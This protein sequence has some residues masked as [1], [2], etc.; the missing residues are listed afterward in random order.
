MMKTLTKVL[1]SFVIT[2]SLL[3]L[4]AVCTNNSNIVSTFMRQSPPS[5]LPANTYISDTETQEADVFCYA[6]Q[7]FPVCF[8][9]ATKGHPLL[10]LPDAVILPGDWPPPEC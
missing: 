8:H 1:N 6:E 4:L 10:H 7:A 9:V 5:E 3:T 2:G